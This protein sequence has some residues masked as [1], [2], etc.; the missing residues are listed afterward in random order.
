MAS[1]YRPT[2]IRFLDSQGRQVR[3]GTPG[4]RR[5]RQKSKTIWGRY[6]DGEGEVQTV[7]LDSDQETAESML[8]DLVKRARRERSGDADPYESSRLKP[9][10]EHIDEFEQHLRSKGSSAHHVFKTTSYVRRTANA[11]GW[12]RLKDIK[13]ADLA[14][15]LLDRRQAS[16]VDVLSLSQAAEVVIEGAGLDSPP[17]NQ[18]RRLVKRIP[19]DIAAK[20]GSAARWNWSVLRPLLCR[21]FNCG[22]PDQCPLVEPGM[23]IAGS[24]DYVAACK[25]FGNWLTETVPKRWPENP[26]SPVGK[27]NAEEDVRLDRRPATHDELRR[28]VEAAR[29]GRPFRGLSGRDRAALYLT[30]AYTGLRAHELA[31][32]TAG[33]FDLDSD[34]PV[35]I[36][37][38]GYSKRR[39][40]DQQPIR[41]D[42]AALLQELVS[43]LR[44]AELPTTLPMKRVGRDVAHARLWPGKWFKDAAEMLRIDLAAAGIAFED[45]GGMVLDFHA[46][47]G[48][49]ATM[50][51]KSGVSPKAAQEL[52]RHS[53]IRLTMQTYTNLQV[54]DVAGSLTQLPPIP[55]SESAQTMRA[56]GTDAEFTPM[57]TVTT[58]VGVATGKASLA[59]AAQ[60]GSVLSC[61]KSCNATPCDSR[62]QPFAA[63][64]IETD[65]QTTCEQQSPHFQAENEGFHREL[66]ATEQEPPLG[67]EPRTYALRKQRG[68]STGVRERSECREKRGFGLHA[69]RH[70]P[71]RSARLGVNRA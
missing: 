21:E 23:S 55:W 59:M 35:I 15:Y 10:S 19:P 28:L 8:A 24:N 56:T 57:V 40:K 47:R 16:I 62:L 48:T 60:D 11:C 43:E 27:L 42:L 18:L 32:L 1:T 51:S 20:R 4:A 69:V 25:N 7:S 65:H 22:L 44:A 68:V 61:T 50:L 30:A 36:V 9:L 14:N 38:A 64:S 54:R 52:M 5:V 6:R 2:V 26:F 39:R 3:K 58:A 13:S 46:L 49:F 37:K 17:M 71:Q 63:V 41:P 53:D 67:F 12:K 45:S 29:Q 34:P 33:S 70:C 66:T 31:T